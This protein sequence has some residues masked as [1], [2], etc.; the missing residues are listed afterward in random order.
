[1]QL[2]KAAPLVAPVDA[3]QFSR[4]PASAVA[5]RAAS[6]AAPK[7]IALKVRPPSVALLFPTLIRTEQRVTASKARTDFRR[8]VH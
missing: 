2:L 3:A 6:I 5:V 1:M 7:T 8:I 4:L